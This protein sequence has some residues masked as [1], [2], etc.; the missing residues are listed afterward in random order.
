L[1]LLNP[2]GGEYSFLKEDSSRKERY[3]IHLRDS[4][5]LGTLV[6]LEANSG[7]CREN[8]IWHGDCEP[9]NSGP[10]SNYWR[11]LNKFRNIGHADRP[12]P[13]YVY[14]G[15]SIIMN[16]SFSFI[17]HLLGFKRAFP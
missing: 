2:C 14:K 4:S 7:I 11:Y 12:V 1:R 13:E 17:S 5:G 15:Y 8:I 6:S 9:E 16:P 3:Y 10:S